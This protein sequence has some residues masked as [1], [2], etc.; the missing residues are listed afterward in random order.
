MLFY[1]HGD[2]KAAHGI[3]VADPLA[4]RWGIALHYLGETRAVTHKGL[5]REAGRL[6]SA[7]RTGLGATAG[8]QGLVD[9]DTDAPRALHRKHPDT[10]VSAQ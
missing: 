2:R 3:V 7:W 5:R 9:K 8:L 4:L 10:C 6:G 1:T